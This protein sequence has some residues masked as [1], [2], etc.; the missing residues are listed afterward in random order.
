MKFVAIAFILVGVLALAAVF[1]VIYGRANTWEV[2]AGDPDLGP[3]DRANPVRSARPN[4]A[5]LCTPNLCDGVRA[6]AD[7]PEYDATPGELIARIEERFRASGEIMERVDDSADPARL[8][9]V[10]WTP[11]FRFPDTNNFEAVALAKGKTGLVAY[12]RAQI[13]HSDRGKNLQRLRAVTG[14][15]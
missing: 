6:D 8:R 7:L 9:I 5:L 14:G 1:F 12:A 11:G 13:G 10:T 15:L 4:D 3:F 2:L